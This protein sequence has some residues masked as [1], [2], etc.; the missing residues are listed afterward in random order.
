MASSP[1]AVTRRAIALVT[2][3]TFVFAIAWIARG[4]AGL[5]QPYD[6]S[7]IGGW[8]SIDPDGLYH[9]R[10]VAR[11]LDEGLPA[12]GSD[13]YLNWPEGAAIPWPPYYDT[14][15]AAVLGPFAPADTS[16][17]FHWLERSVAALPRLFGVAAALAAALIAWRLVG[18]DA[19]PRARDAA[20]VLAGLYAACGWGAVNYSRLGTGDHH[21]FVGLCTALLFGGVTLAA[22][23]FADARRSAGWGV[24]CGAVAALLLGSWVASAA[25][26]VLVQ[27]ALGWFLV[28][29]AREELPGVAS[30]GLALHVSAFALLAPAVLASPW[31]AEFPWMVVN[32][33]WFHLAWLGLGALVFVAPLALGRSTLAAGTPAAR[34][35]PLLVALALAGLAG[36]LWITGSAPARGVAEG[37][38]W[39]SRVDSFMDSVRESEPLVGARAASGELF[40]ALGFGLVVA[41]LA[42][43]AAARRAWRGE[44]AW[45]VWTIAAPVLVAQALAQK[46]FS[47]VAVLP[48]A[49]LLGWGAARLFARVPA[50]VALPLAL[51][52]GLALQGSSVAKLASGKGRVR[53]EAGGRRDALLGE[54]RALEW[55][56]F[57]GSEGDGAVIAH[58][59]RGHFVEWV[60]D[61]PS[62]ATNFGSYVGVD[63][64]RAPAEFFLASD[65]AR[66]EALLA[67]RDVEYVYAPI[68]LPRLVPSMCRIAELPLAAYAGGDGRPSALWGGTPM[69]RVLSDGY[70]P[71][72][73]GTA[74]ENRPLD[75]LRLV[76]V[77]HEVNPGY[78]DVRTGLP[79]PA[80]FVWQRVAG[81]RVSASGRAGERLELELELAFERAQYALTW[82]AS[83]AIGGDGLARLR[84]PYATDA[85]NGDARVV[86][87]SW[88]LGERGGTLT[89]PGRAVL[90]GGAVR[91]E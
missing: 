25:W 57:E 81:A 84:V 68:S 32:L 27:L 40:L 29:R 36:L 1:Q 28:R 15:L 71:I 76:H 64:Y 18:R 79:R 19:P 58:W 75:F 45:A 42:W 86:R 69:A 4:G 49:V 9:T 16:E 14:L 20:A 61:R 53:A 35:Y 74:A 11:A 21:A 90:E 10:R 62:V 54:R 23:A 44:D 63:S 37:F 91:L 73:A 46:R 43:F 59:D 41:P 48:L 87:A 3:L 13:P 33:S 47:D 24:A 77:T 85:S 82:R 5:A 89:L 8:Y 31:R 26:I 17:R 38:A 2:A 88:R 30:F 51:V 22:G 39:V 67:E 72:P 52:A 56:R 78:P 83:A 65:L 55:I 12:A 60:A 6:D 66:A 7:P 50:A 70:A 80:A 34:R